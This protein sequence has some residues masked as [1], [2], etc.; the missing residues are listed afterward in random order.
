MIAT[1]GTPAG[2]YYWHV[3]AMDADGNMSPW[4][5]IS[6]FIVD[7][8]SLPTTTPSGTD[9]TI[10]GDVVGGVDPHGDLAVTSVVVVN[11]TATANGTFT[12]GWKY[13]FNI[14]VPDDETNLSM[15]FANWT[16]NVGSSTI[17]AANN[18]RFSSLQASPTGTTTITA[19]NTYGSPDLHITGD[20]DG[21][22]PGKQVQVMVEV[23]VPAGSVNG[24]Y[25]TS[26]GLRTLP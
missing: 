7:N 8:S 22:T 2:T 21:S 11:G 19:A 18:I 13:T 4:S 5:T 23:A 6:S 15:K 10:G 25:S 1:P 12:S 24:G 14:T 16:S 26:Y 9:G 3:M 20:L 17:P